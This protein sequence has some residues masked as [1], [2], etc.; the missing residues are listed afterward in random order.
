MMFIPKTNVDRNS[1]EVYMKW[2]NFKPKFHNLFFS[3]SRLARLTNDFHTY[4][5]PM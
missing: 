1:N 5:I 3:S 4:L 2:S